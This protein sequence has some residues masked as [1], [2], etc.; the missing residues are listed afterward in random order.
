MLL[1]AIDPN[2]GRTWQ[3][4]NGRRKVEGITTISNGEKRY[5]VSTEGERAQDLIK[6]NEL[7]RMV[8]VDESNVKSRAAA[9]IRQ[10]ADD[11]A[12]K[13]KLSLDGFEDTLNARLR[14]RAVQALCTKGIRVNGRVYNTIRDAIREVMKGLLP[15]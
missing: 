3:S 11:E 4:P 10:A 2:V 8:M 7:D 6:P 13:A 1:A 9:A 15:G 5:L 12:E 14:A